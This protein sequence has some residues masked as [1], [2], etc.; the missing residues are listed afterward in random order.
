[1]DVSAV[2]LDHLRGN[3]ARENFREGSL[4]DRKRVAHAC[5]RVTDESHIIIRQPTEPSEVE[6]HAA[7]CIGIGGQTARERDR[8][9]DRRGRAQGFGPRRDTWR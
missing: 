9:R 3:E 2:D 7:G 5:L 6:N 1:M 4:P 8:A